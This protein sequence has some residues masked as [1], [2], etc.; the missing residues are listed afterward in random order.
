M[1]VP[2]AQVN[3]IKHLLAFGGGGHAKPSFAGG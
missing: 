1:H 2:V 3:V